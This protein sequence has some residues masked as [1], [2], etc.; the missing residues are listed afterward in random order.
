M[1]TKLLW[2]HKRSTK[3]YDIVL[4][5]LKLEHS[6]YFDKHNIRYSIAYPNINNW[7]EVEKR[8]I[9]CGNDVAFIKRSFYFILWRF[10]KK[11]LWKIICTKW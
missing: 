2:C 10:Y 9:D 6:D 3:E 8:C 5:Q 11:K 1:V 4:I 7:E